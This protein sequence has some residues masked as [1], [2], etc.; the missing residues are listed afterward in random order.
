M[1]GQYP[2]DEAS[3]TG[4]EEVFVSSSLKPE[5]SAEAIDAVI[6]RHRPRSRSRSSSLRRRRSSSLPRRST[7]LPRRSMSNA[8][9]TS[10]LRRHLS[11]PGSPDYYDF[12]WRSIRDLEK[13]QEEDNWRVLQER[14]VVN[15]GGEQVH[16]YV[17]QDSMNNASSSHH[18][19]TTVT[20][21]VKTTTHESPYGLS[22]SSGAY[23]P[24]ASPAGSGAYHPSR[25]AEQP[26]TPTRSHLDYSSASLHGDPGYHGNSPVDE[27]ARDNTAYDSF[28]Q[29]Y[30]YRDV[31]YVNSRP[32]N[33][34][35]SNESPYASVPG[36]PA[37]PPD[38]SYIQYADEDPYSRGSVQG[39]PS[40]PGS[41]HNLTP[42]HAPPPPP[43]GNPPNGYDSRPPYG[44]YDSYPNDEYSDRTPS[45]SGGYTGSPRVEDPYGRLRAPPKVEDPYGRLGSP[46]SDREDP[47]GGPLDDGRSQ[48][49]QRTA[50][51]SPSMERS[52]IV[53]GSQGLLPPRHSPLPAYTPNEYGSGSIPNHSRGPTPR[54]DLDPQ[55]FDDSPDYAQQP[56]NGT[57]SPYGSHRMAPDT[58]DYPGTPRGGYP[59]VNFPLGD[60]QPKDQKWR[61]PDLPEVIEFLGSPNEA[62]KANAAAYL[63][64]LCYMDDAT[65]A[66][67]RALGGIPVLVELVGN[68]VPEVHRSAC[69]ALR[70]LSYGKSNDENKRAI[71]NAGGIPA[72]VR[73]LRRTPDN[74]VKELV[75]GILWNLSSCQELKKAIID[76]GLR[77]LVD[78]VIVPHSGFDPE[79]RNQPRDVYWSTVFR[80]GSGVLRNISSDGVYARNKIR[81]CSGLVEAILHTIKAAIGNNGMDNK[82]VENCV[83]ILRNLSFA[84]QEVQD[85]DYLKNRSR[86]AK[87]GAAK[88]QD[89]KSSKNKK[90]S[91]DG[92]SDSTGCFGGSNDSKSKKKKDKG[93]HSTATPVPYSSSANPK[94][95]E[96][97]WHES[98][99]RVYLPLLR[100]CTNPETLEAAAGAVQNLAACEWEPAEIF[101]GAFRK[102]KGLPVIVELLNLEADRVVCSAAMALRNLALDPR[103]K[104]LIG[105][106]A[107]TELCQKLPPTDPL[108]LRE[109]PVTDQTLCSVLVALYEVIKNNLEF[110]STLLKLGGVESLVFVVHKAPKERFTRKVVNF[111]SSLLQKMWNYPELHGPYKA[112]NLTQQDFLTRP[113]PPGG[114][115]TGKSPPVS[116]ENTLHRPRMDQS[117]P[118]LAGYNE[119]TLPHV[120]RQPNNMPPGYMEGTVN[121]QDTYGSRE[122]V[123]MQNLNHYNENAYDSR[124]E[125]PPQR[126]DYDAYRDQDQFQNES[127]PVNPDLYSEH[128]RGAPPDLYPEQRGSYSEQ[129]QRGQDPYPDDRGVMYADEDPY[130]RRKDDFRPP[131]GGVAIFPPN[132]SSTGPDDVAD[133]GEP[134]YARVNKDQSGSRRDVEGQDGSAPLP[135]GADSWITACRN[136]PVFFAKEK[137]KPEIWNYTKEEKSADQIRLDQKDSSQTHKQR[138]QSAIDNN[139]HNFET[140]TVFMKQ[141]F[142]NILC[143]TSDQKFAMTAFVKL[144]INKVKQNQDA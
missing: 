108:R 55:H 9:S 40:P 136:H 49:S 76:E 42:T 77:V 79:S 58:D 72:L 45:Y 62:T 7:S 90:K 15:V 23:H 38:N 98:I 54:A 44:E 144:N 36:R 48:R 118:T 133:G 28:D 134:L 37:P 3:P 66:K 88:E 96:L 124:G 51:P 120:T 41:Y 31:S 78:C 125:Y 70:N 122:N 111:A 1:K 140:E 35:P 86:A 82:S 59:A 142:P 91:K 57:E 113:A 103:N 109:Y 32:S 21:V 112:R 92:N 97:L 126:A 5:F 25:S 20:R 135:G 94:G 64:H 132:L 85:K 102:E 8:S 123:P 93:G 138:Y 114:K 73:L 107:M 104:E 137:S 47:Y 130:S 143:K 74:D 83:C 22:P 139:C 67:T 27:L 10:S 128:Q 105:K 12:C 119:H 11:N 16:N 106:Y 129:Q 26:V 121:R 117:G 6:A 75:T 89:V 100:E 141:I 81:E 43:Q 19:V 127:Y 95:Q 24:P 99:T 50:S 13:D 84:C 131:P 33:G 101:R 68:A 52:G 2:R 71:K 53:Y 46:R 4:E 29:Q 115:T 17:P 65:K 30:S 61:N 14:G 87:N 60:S 39:G 63:Q 116:A 110:A 80:N 18:T 34:P 69:G 56:T